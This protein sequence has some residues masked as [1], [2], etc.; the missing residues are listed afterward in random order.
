MDLYAEMTSLIME[1]TKLFGGEKTLNK[2][3][4]AS[5]TEISDLMR[6]FAEVFEGD[7]VELRV[8]E[9]D[10]SLSMFVEIPDFVLQNAG[11]EFVHELISQVDK[12]IVHWKSKQSIMVEFVITGIW[13]TQKESG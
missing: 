8:N 9:G 5:L 1:A 13:D 6:L 11:D 2:D 7:S 12:F 10:R 3:R 4:I